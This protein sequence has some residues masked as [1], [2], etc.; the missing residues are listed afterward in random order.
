[1]IIQPTTYSD[2]TKFVNYAVSLKLKGKDLSLASIA[3]L[4][5]MYVDSIGKSYQSILQSV[6]SDYA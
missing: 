3:E 4:E 1:M 6:L 2:K 5:Q